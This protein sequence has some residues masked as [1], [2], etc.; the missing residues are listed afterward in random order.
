MGKNNS[1]L[2][3]SK[4]NKNK[5]SAVIKVATMKNTVNVHYAK[6]P[7]SATTKPTLFAVNKGNIF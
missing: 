5:S 2:N 3:N 1:L 6:K 7:S 4:L